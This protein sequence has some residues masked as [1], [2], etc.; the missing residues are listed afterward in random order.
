MRAKLFLLLILCLLIFSLNATADNEG[1]TIQEIPDCVLSGYNDCNL[2]IGNVFR[3]SGADEVPNGLTIILPA[4]YPYM[5]E[6]DRVPCE[7]KRDVLFAKYENGEWV[8]IDS[9]YLED[10]DYFSLHA[11]VD[12]FGDYAIIID[13]EECEYH[14]CGDWQHFMTNPD[15]AEIQ[16]GS[17]LEF[18]FCDVPMGCNIDED[19]V[20]NTY[21]PGNYDPDCADVQV[22]NLPDNGCYPISESDTPGVL[23]VC[24]QDCCYPG[25]ELGDEN[26]CIDSLD[27]DCVPEDISC[28]RIDEIDPTCEDLDGDGVYQCYGQVG[29]NAQ[30]T[31][32]YDS[33]VYDWNI[34]SY[35]DSEV[36]EIS[37]IENDN[38]DIET[39]KLEVPDNLVDF[40][41]G[42][43]ISEGVC[44]KEGVD[45]ESECAIN[46]ATPFTEIGLYPSGGNYY[47]YE[48]EINKP[49]RRHIEF[50]GYCRPDCCVTQ[51]DKDKHCYNNADYE[52]F[53]SIKI[54][55]FTVELY[56]GC[57]YQFAL[58]SEDDS[59][60]NKII[61][62]GDT[63]EG[64][65]Y[66]SFSG[67]EFTRSLP[68]KSIS[69]DAVQPSDFNIF[70][71]MQVYPLGGCYDE[72]ND[73]FGAFEHSECTYEQLDCDDAYPS[74]N[75]YALEICDGKDNDCDEQIDE[76]GVCT[77]NLYVCGDGDVPPVNN[78]CYNKTFCTVEM[79]DEDVKCSYTVESEDAGEYTSY[80]SWVCGEGF[81]CFKYNSGD[82]LVCAEKETFGTCEDNIDND[83]DGDTDAEDSDCLGACTP[84]VCNLE[85]NTWC[86]DLGN[87]VSDNYCHVCG[88]QDSDCQVLCDED[89]TYCESITEDPAN[90]S[91]C[92]ENACDVASDMWCHN[93]GWDST[94]YCDT[95]SLYD[96]DDCSGYGECLA[97]YCDTESNSY[98]S[99]GE[100]VYAYYEQ[101]C[102]G[103][104]AD[105]ESCVE[106]SCDVG[107]N[108]YC[109]SNGWT[110]EDYCLNCGSKDYDCG[111][112]VCS[113]NTCDT[114]AGEWCNNY[115]WIS[116]SY[117]DYTVCGRTGDPYDQDH[118]AETCEAT[119]EQELTCNDGLDNDCDGYFDCT[120]PNC[121]DQEGCA[122]T[123]ED[124]QQCG[125]S[126][127]GICLYGVETCSNSGWGDCEGAVY[128]E[129]E[130]CNTLDD[131]CDGSTD[132]GC[133]C[134][135]G[136]TKNCGTDVGACSSGVQYCDNGLWSI[137]SGSAYS[138]G[139]DEVCDNVDNDCDGEVDENCGC[140]EGMNQTC[141]VDVGICVAGIQFC[142]NGSWS[143]CEDDIES[144][145]EVCNDGLDNDCDGYV[146]NDDENCQVTDDLFPTCYD[147]VMNQD[148]EEIDCGGSICEPCESVSCNDGLRNGNEDGVDCGGSSCPSCSGVGDIDKDSDG[149]GLSDKYESSIGTSAYKVDSDSD[150][151]DDSTDSMPLCPNERCDSSYGETENNCPE[152]CEEGFALPWFYI[153]VFLILLLALVYLGYIYYKK[154]QKSQTFNT[155][156]KLTPVNPQKLFTAKKQE[157]K[158]SKLDQQLES[159]F[160]KTSDLVKKK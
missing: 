38:S 27:L 101:N 105:Y 156:R 160:K 106:G 3:F 107:Q 108:L 153:L 86:D 56:N 64:G 127:I 1:Y 157:F 134:T 14:T 69:F 99:F 93:G 81:D 77:K 141:G 112:D 33:D 135:I 2:V 22:N 65:F 72:D 137:C 89:D 31:L 132:E 159:S 17:D 88:A 23:P 16:A 19:G 85:D 154:K 125:D 29:A 49:L 73:G 67:F 114:Y 133:V 96:Y 55:D 50:A 119:E 145:P 121:V 155:K 120:D 78:E 149:D 109:D 110:T 5:Y 28:P 79:Y 111:T 117:C 35:T 87:Q 146:D 47:H 48:Y 144:F 136:E 151:L 32:D 148:E 42:W 36:R 84:G 100:W 51:N 24:D 83:C 126:D 74:I 57:Q 59:T 40:N 34:Y 62:N 6:T 11:E 140:S 97:G 58:S 53:S 7:D 75:P 52:T 4:A 98:C 152:D 37:S 150:G 15:D 66:D 138:G 20:C 90:S 139:S 143:D 45:P 91:G 41:E 9:S 18:I 142:V 25:K 76:G 44:S 71:K 60:G 94:D 118:C 115:K 82:F 102:G 131:D 116:E 92:V 128:A 13:E 12:S 122:C 103:V 10:E 63:E 43:I 8:E 26:D 130:Y 147:T 80:T 46:D 104:D 61:V 124:T 68:V 21:C 70:M 113:Q 158:P 123:D 30:Y 129:T 39:I 54:R 95:C